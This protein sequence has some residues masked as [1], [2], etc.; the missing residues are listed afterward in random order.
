MLA[1]LSLALCALAAS[2]PLA[3]A[4]ARPN[5]IFIMCVRRRSSSLAVLAPSL[6]A[7]AGCQ[8]VCRPCENG[9][10]LCDSRGAGRTT[11]AGTRASTTRR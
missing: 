9:T 10:L 3:H 1:M 5:L 2:V 4:A 6:A 7:R 8:S 11:R